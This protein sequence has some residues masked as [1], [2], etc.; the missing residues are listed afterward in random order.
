MELAGSAIFSRAPLWP[1]EATHAVADLEVG[2]PCADAFDHARDLRGRRKRE[3]RLDLVLALD[4]QEVEEIQRGGSDRDHGLAG[5]RDRIGQLGQHE[6]VG[7]GNIASREWLSW[8]HLSF[9][10]ASNAVRFMP[11][12][13]PGYNPIRGPAAHDEV[14]LWLKRF[15]TMFEKG[16]LAGKRILV[17]GGGSGLGAAMG[18]RFV[19][20][21][22]EL[23]ICGRRLD[24]LEATAAQ[25]PRR[26]RRQGRRRSDAIFATAPPSMP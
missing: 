11:D 19:E 7:S 8:T 16:L 26:S 20:L 10:R 13:K 21:G 18:R 14:R 1:H 12:L 2:D 24:V 4:H 23:I 3:R 25:A 5:A 22:A 15:K 17:T 9:G 6:I